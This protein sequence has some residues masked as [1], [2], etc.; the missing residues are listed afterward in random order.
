MKRKV[1]AITRQNLLLIFESYGIVLDY[2][3]YSFFIKN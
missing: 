1:I 3:N 2:F